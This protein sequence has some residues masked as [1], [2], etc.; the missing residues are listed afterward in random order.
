MIIV[1]LIALVVTVPVA[2]LIVV[3]VNACHRSVRGD[4]SA[5]PSQRGVLRLAAAGSAVVAL[6]LADVAWVVYA[7]HWAQIPLVT[8]LACGCVAVGA[9]VMLRDRESGPASRR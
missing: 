3:A 5:P 1:V 9:L 6:V 7:L 2:V 8:N 4:A